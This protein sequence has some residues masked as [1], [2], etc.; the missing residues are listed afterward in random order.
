MPPDAPL[1]IEAIVEAGLCIGCGL[2]RS[3]APD[4]M[5][6]EMTPQGA[7]IPKVRHPL[8]EAEL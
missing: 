7:E 1:S 8:T 3:I 2:C 4:A 5:R 6:I